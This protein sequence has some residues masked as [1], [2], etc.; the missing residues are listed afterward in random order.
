MA[1]GP[2]DDDEERLA[3][4][5]RLIEAGDMARRRLARDIHDGAQQ[6]F[7]TALIRL[8][9]A[10]QAWATNP[11]RARQMLAAGIER[12]EQGLQ[13]LREL[14][15]GIHPPLL[16]HQGLGAAVDALAAGVPLPV[17]LNLTDERLPSGMEASVYFFV[18]EALTNVVKHAQASHASVRVAAENGMLVV[19][20]VDD[21]IGGAM[22]L[23]WGTGLQGLEDRVGALSGALTITSAEGAGTALHAEIPLPLPLPLPLP[24]V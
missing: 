14:V 22:P 2:Q 15:A 16:T 5:R 1:M 18:S 24:R 21:G 19:D 12:A 17:D 7:V 6:Q 9:L 20:V 10:Q 3:V 23:G 4:R 8:Q 11:E 13:S